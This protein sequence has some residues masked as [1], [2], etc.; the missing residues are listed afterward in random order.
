MK[1]HKPKT[2]DKTIAKKKGGNNGDKTKSK[3]EK[4]Q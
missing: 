1:R 2:M 4:I 3:K